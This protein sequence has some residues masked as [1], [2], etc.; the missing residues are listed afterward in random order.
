MTARA[1][2]Q[3]LA[4]RLADL[5]ALEVAWDGHDARPVDG[6]ALARARIVAAS[7]ESLGARTSRIGAVPYPDGS[8]ELQWYSAQGGIYVEVALRFGPAGDGLRVEDGPP[9]SGVAAVV[10]EAPML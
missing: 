10:G 1:D 3:S 2:R 5:D 9:A 8:V 7:L 4:A 6:N